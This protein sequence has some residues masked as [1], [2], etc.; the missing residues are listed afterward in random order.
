[1]GTFGVGSNV[2]IGW[3]VG[4]MQ[5]SDEEQVWGGGSGQYLYKKYCFVCFPDCLSIVAICKNVKTK[6]PANKERSRSS[7]VRGRDR[8]WVVTP[9]G[10]AG[11]KLNAVGQQNAASEVISAW[12][13]RVMI[14]Q[15]Q[16]KLEWGDINITYHWYPSLQLSHKN[17]SDTTHHNCYMCSASSILNENHSYNPSIMSFRQ[18][19]HTIL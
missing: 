9:E 13:D 14:Q 15:W 2:L 19:S 10:P 12:R 18:Q 3:W 16:V 4:D 11:S 6:L 17:C 5:A 1:M 8:K 7:P